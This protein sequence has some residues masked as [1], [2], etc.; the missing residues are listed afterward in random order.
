[1]FFGKGR[2]GWQMWSEDSLWFFSVREGE[3]DNHV[4]LTFTLPFVKQ[5]ILFSF[6]FVAFVQKFCIKKKTFYIHLRI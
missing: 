2:R 5:N 4:H 3:G 1:M 6:L